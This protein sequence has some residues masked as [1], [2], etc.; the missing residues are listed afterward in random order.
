MKIGC[1]SKLSELEIIR[2]AGYDY[3][4]LQGKEVASI[5]E[6]EF[7]RLLRNVQRTH[8]PCVSLNAYCREGIYIAGPRYNRGDNKRYAEQLSRRAGALG[9]HN[10]GIGSPAARQIPLGFDMETAWSQTIEFMDETAEVFAEKNILVGIEP[11]GYCF[12]NLINCLGEAAV[13]MDALKNQI[14]ITLDF[15]NMEQSFEADL[16]LTPY[17]ANI[18]H[19]HISDD[20]GSCFQR[21]PLKKNRYAVHRERIKRLLA[22]GYTGDLTLEVDTPAIEEDLAESAEFLHEVCHIKCETE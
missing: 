18:I 13:L 19:A 15:Y 11:L 20:F 1:T 12:C 5:D 6:R 3:L 22:Y 17:I 4:V 16:D 14:G 10:V 7:Q 8:L 2:S 9:V 21:S